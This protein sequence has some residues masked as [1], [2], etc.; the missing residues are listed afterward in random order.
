MGRLEEELGS[1]LFYRHGRGVLLTDIG[2]QLR[3]TVE[4]LIK[5]I[6]Q[7]GS[8]ISAQRGQATG[9]V[10][11][12][13]PPSIGRSMAASAVASFRTRCPT[14]RLHVMEG[15]SG[16]L[17]QWLESGAVDVAI[18]YD[19]RRSPNMVFRDPR[20]GVLNSPF[21][22]GGLNAHNDV[23]LAPEAGL[24][25]LFPNWLEHHV[26]PHD[27]EAPRISISFNAT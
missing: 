23:Q 4:P 13:I 17:A 2:W 8:E 5:A 22:G 15:S 12:G 21:K 26:E 10:R 1:A 20:P 16:T 19:A 3:T 25:V 6:D 27:N 9:Q 24:V 14:A 18:L 11:L 7:L